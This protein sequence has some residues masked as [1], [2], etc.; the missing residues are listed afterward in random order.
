[1]KLKLLPDIKYNCLIPVHNAG[2]FCSTFVIVSSKPLNLSIQDT[3]DV[4]EVNTGNGK[5]FDAIE[6]YTVVDSCDGGV[7]FSYPQTENRLKLMFLPYDKNTPTK[8]IP[9]SQIRW[10]PI[11][12]EVYLSYEGQ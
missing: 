3:F 9:H 5:V 8:T 12:D 10:T 2:V 4:H 7:F 11:R 6:T 1:M